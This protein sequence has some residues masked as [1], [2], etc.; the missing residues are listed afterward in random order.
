ML[1]IAILAIMFSGCV[2]SAPVVGLLYNDTTYLGHGTGGIVDNDVKTDK[3]GISTC[4]SVLYLFASGDCSVDAA[5][6]NGNIT[7][8]NSIDHKAK[9]YSVFYTT[10]STVVNGE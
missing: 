3:T 6:K 7:K 8:V 9:S 5:K 2:K 4:S 1:P 10:Y